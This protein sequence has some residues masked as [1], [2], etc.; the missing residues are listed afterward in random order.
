[1]TSEEIRKK[2]PITKEDIKRWKK[3]KDENIDYSDI[4]PSMDEQLSSAKRM[5]RPPKDIHKKTIS[6]RLYEY[7]LVSLRQS[8]RG[9]QT[10]VS[11]W[12]SA[13]LKKGVL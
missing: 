2:Y 7:D 3:I 13:G 11:D 8:G 5:G 10:R 9:W 6:I 12:V 1:M 4:P